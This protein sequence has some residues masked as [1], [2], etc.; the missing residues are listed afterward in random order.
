MDAISHW[1]TKL[2]GHIQWVPKT[3][4]TAAVYFVRAS[5]ASTC[6]SSVGRKG[7]EQGISVGDSCAKG[8]VIHEMG[9]AVGLWHEQSREDR[10]TFVKILWENINGA[11]TYNFT[12]NISNG[13][14]LGLYDYGS[15]M[16]YPANCVFLEWAS[17][18]LK[19]FPRVYP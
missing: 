17:P 13:D 12:Q 10:D 19:R 2:A 18:Q 14:D 1:N 8:N 6:S 5:S 16:H 15:I 9:H 11:M 3:N 7:Y 4:E